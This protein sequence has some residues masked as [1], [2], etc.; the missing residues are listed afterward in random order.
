MG[1]LSCRFL[2][3]QFHN[4]GDP[5]DEFAIGGFA[6]FGADGVAEVA[7]Q[8]IH[9]ASGPGDLHQMADGATE[10]TFIGILVAYTG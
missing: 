10:I 6:F 9:V 1:C 5:G 2:H 4:V 3:A 8:H 7:H